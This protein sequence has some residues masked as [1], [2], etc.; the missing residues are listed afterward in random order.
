MTQIYTKAVCD[1]EH[2]LQHLSFSIFAVTVIRWLGKEDRS[3]SSGEQSVLSAS[4]LS[5]QPYFCPLNSNIKF[6][7]REYLVYHN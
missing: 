4:E 2:S 5:L 7:F 1:L 3:H 6:S